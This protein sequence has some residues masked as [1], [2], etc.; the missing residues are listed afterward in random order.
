MLKQKTIFLNHSK[1]E[2]KDLQVQQG[3]H[4][5]QEG[6]KPI[7]WTNEEWMYMSLRV[8]STIYLCHADEVLQNVMIEISA[9]KFWMKLESLYTTKSLTNKLYLKQQLYSLQMKETVSV[10]QHL[11][12]FNKNIGQLSSIDVKVEDED[13]ALILLTSFLQS[14]E[15]LVTI[16]LYGKYTIELEEV[17]P[18]MLS[19]EKRKRPNTKGETT[20]IGCQGQDFKTLSTQKKG[21]I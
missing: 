3:L 6:K 10:V 15:H 12:V 16:M 7:S 14:Y 13:K 19:N 5:A 4:K 8:V 9:P 21:M 20:T 18:T 1:N 11:N 17:T 2:V